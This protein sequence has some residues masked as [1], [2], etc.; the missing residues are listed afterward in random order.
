MTAEPFLS[1]VVPV[2]RAEHVLTDTL[3]ALTAS[4]LERGAWE[5]VVVDDASPD[6]SAE[7]AA[8]FADRVVRLEG[9]PGGPAR[10]RNRGSEAC[11]GEVLVFVDA[12][13]RVA[14]DA[15]GK[16]ADLFRRDPDLAAAFGSY[17]GDPPAPGVVSRYRN[18]LHHYHHH[19]GAGDAETFWAGL[20][21][22]RARIFRELGGFDEQ[23]Y[24]R[25]QIE[26]I[27]L[28]RRIR[29]AG[30]R[31]VLDPTIQ[32]A[33]LKRWTLT[34]VLKTD[35]LHRGIPWMRLIL[36][37]D[38]GGQALNVRPREKLCVA[39]VG[40]ALLALVVSAVFG[41]LWALVLALAALGV[42]AAL[43]ARLYAYLS[44]GRGI[45]F[46]LAVVPLHLL[47]YV[48]SGL[49][50]LLGHA[51]HRLGPRRPPGGRGVDRGGLART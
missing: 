36:E 47:Y 24:A 30:H 31:I 50:F 7:V 6:R 49:A 40:L 34:Q 26:D 39:L 2:H 51:A 32:G 22:V 37:E 41:S 10:A 48:T 45:G 29:L 43:N 46:R 11:R 35:L 3:A 13:V 18:L 5:L 1:V 42:V 4:R 8:R 17:D 14:P 9:P 19:A 12:D 20:G 33:H 28:G 44:R 23:R 15:L 16:I 25:P 21:A 38:G 27:E